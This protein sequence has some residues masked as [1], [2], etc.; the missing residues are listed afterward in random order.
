VYTGSDRRHFADSI[1]TE[2]VWKAWL[3]WIH[4]RSEKGIRGV[5]SRESHVQEHVVR[6]RT[7][8]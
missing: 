4:P 1:A 8:I 2:N 6:T 7:R 3:G 5:Q